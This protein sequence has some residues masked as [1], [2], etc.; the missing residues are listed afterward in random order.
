MGLTPVQ[1]WKKHRERLGNNLFYW[2]GRVGRKPDDPKA[3]RK[4]SAAEPKLA[5]H[6]SLR[7]GRWTAAYSG[8]RLQLYWNLY[9]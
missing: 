2:K 8:T 7:T 9:T 5:K 3:L 6:R 4:L 1:P